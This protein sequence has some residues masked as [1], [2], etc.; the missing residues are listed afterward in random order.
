MR[1]PFEELRSLTDE[2]GPVPAL[3]AREVRRRGDRMRRRRNAL[4]AVGAA[5]AVAALTSGGLVVNDALTGA[6][7]APAPASQAPSRPAGTPTP[8]ETSEAPAVDWVTEIPEGFPL[9]VGLPEPGGDVPEWTWSDKKSQPLSAVA[10]GGDE[11]LSTDSRRA[12]SLRVQVTPPDA[13]VWRHVILF[14]DDAAARQA[15]T[16]ARSSAIVC[17]EMSPVGDDTEVT[18]ARWEMTE[19][20]RAGHPVVQVRGR[21]YAAGTETRVPGRVAT[22]V[23]RVGNALLVARIDDAASNTEPDADEQQLA[24]DVDTIV[25]AMCAFEAEP[26]AEPPAVTEVDAGATAEQTTTPAVS[27]AETPAVEPEPTPELVL[28]DTN[29]IEGGQIPWVESSSGWA[30][31]EPVDLPTLGC[32]PTW[33]SSLGATETVSREFRAD[34]GS[35]QVGE[36]STA[37][38]RFADEAQA[39]EAVHTVRLWVAECA[40]RLDAQRRPLE[41]LGRHFGEVGLGQGDTAWWRLVVTRP[42]GCSDCDARWHEAQGAA[43]LDDRLL[44]VSV[45]VLGT[46]DTPD[47]VAERMATTLRTA[48]EAARR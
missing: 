35:R 21:I 6:T 9:A 26:C 23:V 20:R 47:R 14:E 17:A 29:L 40:D 34:A 48:A 25:A 36:A 12:D 18:E 46:E 5:V 44:L 38:L 13:S 33:L 19:D 11:Q 37:V 28:D 8:A 7:P 41:S 3:P 24:A 16:D 2:G 27:P 39:Q 22:Q 4:S 42:A 32:Q 31:H 10:C 30:S 43:L 15:Y 1:D 45:D